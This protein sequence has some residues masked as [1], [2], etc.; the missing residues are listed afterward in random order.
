[1]R[2]FMIMRYFIP[3][4]MLLSVVLIGCNKTETML[5]SSD[6]RVNSF[7]FQSDTTNPGLT[8]AVYK[9]EH[10]ADTGWIYNID[11]LAYGTRI[12]SVVPMVTY[13]ATPGSATFILPD[14]S[15][16]ST[17]ADTIDFTKSPVYLYVRSSDLEHEKWYRIHITVHQVDPDLYVWKQLTEQIFAPQ[18]CETQALLV[19]DELVVYVNNGFSTELYTSATGENWTKQTSLTG[20]PTPCSVREIMQHENTLYYIANDQL[21]WSQD[22]IHWTATDYS[23]ANFSPQTMLMNFDGKAWCVVENRADSQLYLATVTDTLIQPFTDMQ[24]LVD[25]ALP[26]Q[27]PISDFAALTFKSSSERPRA[28]VVGGRA[29]NG[30]AVNTRWNFEYAANSGYRLKDFTIEQPQ[31]NSLTGVSIIQYADHLM[32]FGGIDN[33]LTW[34]S[35]MLISDDEGMNWHMPD[36]THNQLPKTYITRQKQSVLVDKA[37]NIYIIGGQNQTQSFSDV[38]R[39]YLNSINW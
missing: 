34:R 21:Y 11:S 33:D 35:D 39:G 36:T 4:L 14:T 29:K 20:L 10:R 9:V 6:A 31:F 27:F 18:Y 7:T 16:T 19:N 30:Q 15:I 24:G 8:S 25:G 13:K 17:G 23:S 3:I 1:M 26:A 38:Y 12:D 37:N 5:T 22:N 2:N 28:M 32:M